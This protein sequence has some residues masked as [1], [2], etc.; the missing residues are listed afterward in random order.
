MHGSLDRDR[1]GS[2][3]RDQDPSA[4]RLP[5]LS[6][7]IVRF[8]IGGASHVIRAASTVAIVEEGEA[9]VSP[10]RT[11][12]LVRLDT[13]EQLIVTSRPRLATLPD[14]DGVLHEEADGSLRWIEHRLRDGIVV[15]ATGRTA[16]QLANRWDDHFA[17]RAER[18]DEDGVVVSAGLRPPQVG[19][20]HAIGAHWSQDRSTATVI[21]PTGTGKTETMLSTLAAFVR[22]TMLVVVPGDV[23]RSQTARKFLTFGLLRRLGALSDDAPN[24]IVGVVHKRPRDASDLDVFRACNVVVSTM[25]A[26]GAGEALA[27]APE[28]AELVDTLVVDE[29]HHIGAEGWSAFRAA[30][31]KRRILQFTATPFRR[32][33]RI[34]DGRV[35]YN[36]PLRAAQ[37]DGYFTSISFEPV[38]EPDPAERD[39]AIA[40]AAIAKLRADLG[41]GHD[42][43]IMARCTSIARAKSVLTLYERLAPDLKPMVVHSESPAGTDACVAALRAGASRVVVCV[44]MLGEGFDLPQLKIAAIHDPQKSLAVFLQFAGRFTRTAGAR[45]GSATAIADVADPEVPPAM[46]RLYGEDADWNVLLSDYS[47]EATREHAELVA[48]LNA[49][50]RLDEADD[51]LEVS[52]RLLRPVF[53]TLVFRAAAFRPQRFHAGLPDGFQVHRAW[54]HEQSDTLFFVTR[55]ERPV[56]WTRSRSLRDREWGLFVVHFDADRNLLHLSSTDHSSTFDA[57][58]E[59]VGGGPRLTGDAVFRV[60][61][62]VNRLVFQVVG[63]KKHGRRNLRY[64]MYTGGD[65][66]EA[67]GLSE[68]AGSIKSNLSGTG[69]EDGGPVTIGCSQKGRIWSREQ[70]SIPAFVEW[71]GAVGAKVTDEGID[72]R[73]IMDNV[74][75]PEEVA[76]FPDKEVLGLDWPVELLRKPEERVVFLRGGDE[77][78]LSM[79]DVSVTGLDRTTNTLRFNLVT[80]LGEIWANLVLKVG[81]KGFVVSRESREPVEI[82]AGRIEL[83][84]EQ[85]LSD[86]PPLVRFVDLTEL[87]GDLLIRPQDPQTLSIDEARFE[88]WDWSGVDLRKESIWKDGG[89]RRDSIQWA[90][91]CRQVADG[92]D[93]VFDDDAAGEAADLVCLKEEADHIR[94]AL[95]HCKFAGGDTPGG[96]VKDAVEVASQAV[97]SA[98]WK[99]RFKDLCRH[100]VS[101]DR[102]LA[103]LG[104]PSRFLAGRPADVKRLEKLARLKEVRAE[105]AIVQPGLSRRD[106]TPDQE[107]VLAAAAGYLKLTVAVDLRIVCS[108]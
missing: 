67:L 3:L 105:I 89:E 58:A 49:A 88:A 76:A 2:P 5:E 33:G 62:R 107:A 92:F 21:M 36:Y 102:R 85:Y 13:G 54:L 24:P 22:G 83:P 74:L 8:P 69:W 82:R 15:D 11:E 34:V 73:R 63:V 10:R 38:H 98:R 25:S 60:L 47:S 16:R 32:D 66:A 90:A 28:I 52:S 71:C 26:L 75:I 77:L 64:A 4:L 7:G 97:R 53:N 37:R 87:D 84:L 46:E 35:I 17:F 27:L 70:G 78:P 43:L 61:G 29:A 93:V 14:V 80:A 91:A 106:R 40:T 51:D 68:R 65:V 19:A 6:T 18:V 42:H 57:L 59:A 104:R 12:R 30:F 103:G 23:L 9:R 39:L 94:L 48:F 81:P 95:L 79:V 99:W 56:R 50:R 100:V 1:A 31:A 101:R 72:T 108:P 55:F 86:W 44:N 41:E 20:L 45:L 96:R